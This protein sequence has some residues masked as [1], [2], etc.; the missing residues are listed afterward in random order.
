MT[1]NNFQLKVFS[2][3]GNLPLA[4]KIAQHIGDPLGRIELKNFPDGE[5]W[6]RIDEDI[7]GRDIFVVQPTC[8]PVNENLMEL[9]IM[10]DSFKRASAARITVV[11]PYYGYA[12]QDRK[13][14]GRVPITAKL[15]A[16]LLTSAG[17]QRVITVDLHA[18]QIQGFFDI[19]VDHLYA[20]PVI[21]KYVKDLNIDPRDLIVLS[22]DEGSVKRVLRY[23]KKLNVNMAIVDK[24]R[25]DADKV[26]SANLIG[27][28]LE[29]KVAIIFDDMISTATTVCS[30]A[31]TART[32][33]KARAVY[34]LAT[35]G[36]LCGNAIKN[37]RE[38]PVEKIAITDT[39]PL[40]AEKKLP[41]LD[42]L[43][44]AE[45]LADAIK[46]IHVNQSVSELFV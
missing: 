11:L 25:I 38:A 6:A 8:H 27:A 31:R 33:G 10:L 9:L 20:S 13:A 22:P 40:P 43:S 29:G 24:R 41:N 35:H 44:V 17:A 32:V 21:I 30:A 36:V 18:A 34:I 7:R 26:E 19:P 5:N 3:R 37:L 2:G 15:V 16:N 23:Q 1:N 45:L 39:I 14:E 42:V 4:E 12:R 28:S 46:R